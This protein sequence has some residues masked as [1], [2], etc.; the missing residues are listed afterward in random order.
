[1]TAAGAGPAHAADPP[2]Y[3]KSPIIQAAPVGADQD[4]R[5]VAFAPARV[6]QTSSAQVVA[7]DPQPFAVET[8][9]PSTAPAPIEA[10]G[11]ES[12]TS[13][14]TPHGAVPQ[15]TLTPARFVQYGVGFVAD[16]VVSHGPICRDV[17]TPCI[18][19]DGAG[20]V[21]NFGVALQRA[22]YVGGAYEL[23]R[24]DPSK[25]YRLATLQELRVE[26]RRY[27]D[28]G[29]D[30]RGF[31]QLGLGANVYGDLWGVDTYGPQVQASIGAELELSRR[32]MLVISLDY[33]VAGFVT[34]RDST[35]TVR[36][37]GAAQML[38]IRVSLEGRERW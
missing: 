16:T 8:T 7:A 1:L 21:A 31:L 35:N 36:D 32:S 5:M 22:W 11:L 3:A 15:G 24:R 9:G 29:K 26:V 6:D 18:F 37:A 10:T 23:T 12:P 25:L 38:G 30:L 2:A 13:E 27:Q 33:R 14:R 28:T 34:F 19:G 20:V 4:T 17:R